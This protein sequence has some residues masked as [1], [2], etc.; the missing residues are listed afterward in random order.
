MTINEAQELVDAWNEKHGIRPGELTG[1]AL[2]TEKVGELAR[3]VA[4]KHGESGIRNDREEGVSHP[5]ISEELGEVLWALLSL[6]AQS[7]ADLTEAMIEVLEK[8]NRT[9]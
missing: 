6:S 3:A 2:L 1:I 4:Q 9:K 5:T 7:N 8:K